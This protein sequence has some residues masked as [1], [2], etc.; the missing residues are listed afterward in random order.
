MLTNGVATGSITVQRIDELKFR[1]TTG[2]DPGIS[3]FGI[4][5]KNSFVPTTQEFLQRLLQ[6][7]AD[8]ALSQ[9]TA[10]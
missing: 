1:R 7:R 6:R 10:S 5:E 4:L 8:K 2:L 9:R 3:Q